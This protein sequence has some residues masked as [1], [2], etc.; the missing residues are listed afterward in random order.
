MRATNRAALATAGI[1]VVASAGAFAQTAPPADGQ[2]RASC[3]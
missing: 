3:R 1:L 2:V